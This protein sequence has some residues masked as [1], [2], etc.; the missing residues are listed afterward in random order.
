MHTAK[1][2]VNLVAG[3]YILFYLLWGFNYYRPG[4]NTRTG[5]K[6]SRPDTEE[7][8]RIL[9]LLVER[10]NSSYC[11]YDDFSDTETDSLVEAGYRQ[12]AGILKINYPNGKRRPK[13]VT[14]SR[15]FAR[16]GISGYFGPFFNEIH[17]NRHILPVEYPFVLA[18]EKAHQFGVTSEAEAN[19]MAWLVCSR[20]SSKKLRYS[21]Y[22]QALQSFLYQGS[23]SD[24]TPEA[25][26]RLDKRAKTDILTIYNHWKELRNEHIDKATSK[27]YD[28]YLKS[29]KVERG[30]DDYYGMVKFIMDFSLDSDFNQKVDALRR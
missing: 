4:L 7:F 22:I 5:L 6:E 30:I 10:V 14:F 23:K 28:T 25:L 16:A 26:N 3:F 11:T 8:K 19:F 21:A 27:V 9:S 29:N 20:S 2:L 13:P 17:M 15:F 1:I 12:M 18:H 24:I